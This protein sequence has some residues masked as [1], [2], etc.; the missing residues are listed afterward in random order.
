MKPKKPSSQ[1]MS[2]KVLIP[3]QVHKELKAISALTDVPLRTYILNAVLEK[4][5]KDKALL[6]KPMSDK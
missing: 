5:A 3:H 1:I 4:M 2:S 6:L